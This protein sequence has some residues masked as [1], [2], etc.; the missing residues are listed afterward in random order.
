M[1]IKKIYLGSDHAGY[2]LKNQIALYVKKLRF[3][4]QDLG[5][6]SEK[7][8]D[9]P[10]TAVK[11]SKKVQKDKNSFGILICGTGIG[12]SIAANKF[13]NIRAAECVSEIMAERARKHN[14]ANILCL[15]AR[16]I[17]LDLAKKITKKFLRTNFENEARHKR[18]VKK[19]NAL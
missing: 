17:K 15:G 11:V 13:K 18:R 10:D 2:K 6:F 8:A 7:S 19:L 5:V 9:Y 12:M 14:N 3:K 1:K 16:L 4:T